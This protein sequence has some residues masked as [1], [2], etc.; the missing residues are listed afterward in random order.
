MDHMAPGILSTHKIVMIDKQV[1]YAE[2][3]GL[4]LSSIDDLDLVALAP[5]R[6]NRFRTLPEP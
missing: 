2:A 6:R 3:F 5:Q 4:A 1:S